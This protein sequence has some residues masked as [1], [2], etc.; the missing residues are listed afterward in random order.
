MSFKSESPAKEEGGRECWRSCESWV[1]RDLHL[2]WQGLCP[3]GASE[4]V[5]MHIC[6]VSLSGPQV[7]AAYL[8][9]VLC[10]S[11]LTSFE[12]TGE[13]G[14]GFWCIC[15]TTHFDVTCPLCCESAGMAILGSIGLLLHGDHHLTTLAVPGGCVCSPSLNKFSCW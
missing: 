11:F 2:Y 9:F 6:W 1:T 7:C 3:T 5:G 10:I 13:R 12:G 4:E 8:G 14:R 15:A